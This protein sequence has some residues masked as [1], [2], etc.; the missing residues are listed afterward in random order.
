[1]RG[2]RVATNVAR[3]AVASSTLVA[4][5]VIVSAR[6]FA[7]A[8]PPRDPSSVRQAAQ[9]I[10]AGKDFRRDRSPFAGVFHWLADRLSFTRGATAGGGPGVVGDLIT[11]VLIVAAIV[12]IARLIATRQR[13]IA[14]SE[15]RDEVVTMVGQRRSAD[16]WAAEAEGF[17]RDG[18]FREAVRARYRELVARLAADGTIVEL[19]GKT[20]G[21]L[22]TEVS[23]ARHSASL[24]F[25]RATGLFERAWYG[26]RAVSVED[27]RSFEEVAAEVVKSSREPVRA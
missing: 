17:E 2:S 9:D 16:E 18:L 21:E 27:L 19:V 20:S 14:R 6:A 4:L 23:E 26:G 11:L 1:M 24:P 10:L 3:A 8:K 5:G 15:R 22:L 7:V 25:T 13:R 12:L